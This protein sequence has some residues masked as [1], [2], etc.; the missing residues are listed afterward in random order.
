[1]VLQR[2]DFRRDEWRRDARDNGP[3]QERSDRRHLLGGRHHV[4]S[5][6]AHTGVRLH[7]R[8]P[9]EAHRDGV[10]L[11]PGAHSADQDDAVQAVLVERARDRLADAALDDRLYEP[12]PVRLLQLADRA[13]RLRLRGD[14][15][16][17]VDRRDLHHLP[18]GD[19]RRRLRAVHAGGPQRAEGDGR[20]QGGCGA[21]APASRGGGG[22]GRTEG[23]TRSDKTLS[24]SRG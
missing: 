11:L 1:M 10:R 5:P 21:A 14:H 12:R 22:G 24:K 7:Q 3:L 8:H 23:K 19:R 13:A 9:A 2:Q 18:A 15:R 17:R 16:L 4:S 20:R 6:R